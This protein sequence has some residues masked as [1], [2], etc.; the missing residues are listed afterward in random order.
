MRSKVFFNIFYHQL[1]SDKILGCWHLYSKCG[2]VHRDVSINNVVLVEDAT[3]ESKGMLIDFDMAVKYDSQRSGAIERTGTFD[4]MAIGILQGTALV[5]TPLH[6]L[7]SFLYI[8]LYLGTTYTNG[9]VKV[10]N[11]QEQHLFRQPTRT[12]FYMETQGHLKLALMMYPNFQA[13]VLSDLDETF[14]KRLGK[15][16]VMLRNILWPYIVA[17]PSRLVPI[18]TAEGDAS[19]FDSDCDVP[20]DMVYDPVFEEA[21][22]PTY[23]KFLEEIEKRI[24]SLKGA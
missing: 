16:L 21:Y 8:L 9:K 4:F 12:A 14:R 1:L 23:K 11:H 22:E 17:D 7:E 5:H 20:M 24:S 6:D 19:D 10:T 18:A 2:Y 13:K 3:I 15:M